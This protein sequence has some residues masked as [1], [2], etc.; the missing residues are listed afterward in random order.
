MHKFS[1]FAAAAALGLVAVVSSV[2]ASAYGHSPPAAGAPF[3]ITKV[4]ADAA[5]SFVSHKRCEITQDR[6]TLV[7]YAKS[8]PIL[9]SFAVSHADPE[10]PEL[11]SHIADFAARVQGVPTPTFPQGVALTNYWV[12]HADG[13]PGVLVKSIQ[14]GCTALEDTSSEAQAIVA[15]LDAACL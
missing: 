15:L 12:G 4:D 13:N 10:K 7:T 8:N 1:M 3:V 11:T 9:R 5:G 6:M 2:R 14:D